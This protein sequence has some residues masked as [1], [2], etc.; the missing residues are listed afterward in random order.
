MMSMSPFKIMMAPMMGYTDCFFRYL[1]R[2]IDP[3]VVLFTEMIHANALNYAHEEPRALFHSAEEYPLVVQL[4]GYEPSELANAAEKITQWSESKKAVVG[5]NLNVG[6][7]SSRVQKGRFGACLMR[8]P[9]RVSDIIRAIKSVTDMPVSVKTRL[10]VDEVNDLSLLIP[11]MEEGISA[12]CHEWIIHARKAWLSGLNPKQNRD[13]PPLQYPLVYEIKKRFS[14]TEIILNGGLK[15]ISQILE[16]SK[17]VDGVMLGRVL[18]AHPLWL[19]ELRTAYGEQTLHPSRSEI[20]EKYLKFLA[21]VVAVHRQQGKKIPSFSVMT[22]PLLNLF[23]GLP[24]A[25]AHRALLLQK[26]RDLL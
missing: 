25:K 7:P 17:S 18:C 15:D 21:D 24:H 11:L 12:G 1:L 10:S 14:N 5:I 20:E 8:E 6:C 9:K 16:C 2:C 3:H 26:I 22:K 4:G 13:I 23:H 19:Q